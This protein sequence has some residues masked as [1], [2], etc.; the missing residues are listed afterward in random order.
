MK[1]HILFLF[2]LVLLIF[3]SVCHGENS[4]GFDCKKENSP[5]EKLIC[6]DFR[7][8]SEDHLLTSRYLT[9]LKFL[10]QEEKKI[11]KAEQIAW[12]KKRDQV[13]GQTQDKTNISEIDKKLLKVCEPKKVC[14]PNRVCNDTKPNSG[15]IDEDCLRKICLKKMYEGRLMVLDLKIPGLVK[16]EN[17]PVKDLELTIIKSKQLRGAPEFYYQLSDHEYLFPV[18]GGKEG[19]RLQLG[20]YYADT[21]NNKL[22]QIISGYPIIEGVIKDNDITWLIVYHTDLN[23]GFSTNGYNA[24]LIRDK[25]SNNKPY[26]LFEL[27]SIETPYIEEDYGEAN[28]CPYISDSQK[29]IINSFSELKGYDVKDRNGD[30]I[31]DIVFRIERY[32]CKTNKH[33]SIIETYY[34]LPKDPFIKKMVQKK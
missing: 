12:L 28:P 6:S 17:E 11:L 4:A 20:V 3:S 32:D 9:R 8:S 16:F 10:S 30:G 24:I 21:K 27:A 31:N 29:E 33:S 1:K 18:D 25:K 22:N 26:Q 14:K 19:G 13:C 15:G 34:L 23:R 5:T 7:L 2:C